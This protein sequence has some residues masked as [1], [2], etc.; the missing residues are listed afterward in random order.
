[1]ECVVSIILLGMIYLPIECICGI[2]NPIDVPTRD[3]I[4]DWMA[5]ING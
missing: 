4:V 5:G 2:T 1:M 3:R